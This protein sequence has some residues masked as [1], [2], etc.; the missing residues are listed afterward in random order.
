MMQ[1]NSH[2]QAHNSRICKY[3]TPWMLNNT[4][5]TRLQWKHNISARAEHSGPFRTLEKTISHTNVTVA[6]W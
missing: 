4:Q 3:K 5:T 6:Q 2:I 1:Q